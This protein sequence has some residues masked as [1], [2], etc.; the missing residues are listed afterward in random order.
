MSHVDC[1]GLRYLGFWRLKS[2][3]SFKGFGDQ[4][5]RVLRHRLIHCFRAARHLSV[6]G[7]TA[8]CPEFAPWA[9]T[10]YCPELQYPNS[11][12]YTRSLQPKTACRRKPRM[13]S[14]GCTARPNSE[15][16]PRQFHGLLAAFR[17]SKLLCPPF[18]LTLRLL[19]QDDLNVRPTVN[20]HLG[21]V[22]IGI[23]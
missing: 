3:Y 19:C 16:F 22:G 1:C 17:Q 8:S 2:L 13:Q 4:R 6:C 9:S 7:T 15:V 23:T 10:A 21:S 12:S 11:Q 18:C 5:F 20:S 14:P